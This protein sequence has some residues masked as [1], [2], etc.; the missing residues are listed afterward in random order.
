MADKDLIVV[1]EN[2]IF[3]PFVKRNLVQMN[4]KVSPNFNS[5]IFCSCQ[6]NFLFQINIQR[7]N[8]SF[9]IESIIIGQG[10]KLITYRIKLHKLK[11]TVRQNNCQSVIETLDKAE[12]RA[13][14]KG[15]ETNSFL[16][17]EL[18]EPHVFFAA[19]WHQ[20]TIANR[21]LVNCLDWNNLFAMI[22]DSSVNSVHCFDR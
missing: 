14:E 18:Y 15:P 2:S 9:M 16:V 12:S 10:V 7:H 3:K 19:Y 1:G 5:V 17:I 21:L 4:F 11:K 20:V 13:Q 8:V 6:D 22:S